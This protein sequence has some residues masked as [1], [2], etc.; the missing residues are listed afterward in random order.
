MLGAQAN[1]GYVSTAID[2]VKTILEVTG[3]IEGIEQGINKFMEGS[4][5][6]M[7]ALDEVAKLHPFVGGEFG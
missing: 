5:V 3:G 4:T 6:L 7:N 2:G 1:Q